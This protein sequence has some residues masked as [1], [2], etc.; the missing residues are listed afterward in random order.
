MPKLPAADGC[1]GVTLYELIVSV[2]LIVIF[3]R[4]VWICVSGSSTGCG[5][6]GQCSQTVEPDHAKSNN[7]TSNI[8]ITTRTRSTRTA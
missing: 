5:Y 8:T 4:S 1:P 6:V 3:R 7:G 2:L